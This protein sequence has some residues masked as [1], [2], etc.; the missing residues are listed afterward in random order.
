MARC[1]SEASLHCKG[2]ED[3]DDEVEPLVSIY[4]IDD[5]E[6]DHEFH[7]NVAFMQIELE[8]K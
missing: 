7:N 2:H 8:L 1:S 5:V 6:V 3:H 4:E